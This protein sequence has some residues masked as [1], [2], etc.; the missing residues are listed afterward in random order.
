MTRMTTDRAVADAVSAMT[1]RYDTGDVLDALVTSCRELYPAAAVAV[2]TKAE[3]GALQLMSATSHRSA[4]LELLQQQQQ[5]AGPCVEAMTTGR[6]VTAEG[7]DLQHRWG[8]IGE[9]VLGAGFTGVRAYPMLWRGEALGGL[10]VFLQ[11]HQDTTEGV[12][13]TGQLFADLATLAVVHASDL[14]GD[15]VAS[16]IHEA[17]G[18]RSLVEQAKG[19]IAYRYDVSPAE[20]YELLRQQART[21]GLT[22]SVVA[23]HVVE[24]TSRPPAALPGC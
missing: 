7:E 23:R 1:R 14:P 21:T 5:D 8:G 16:R 6:V 9:A 20:A 3:S 19:V 11:D 18:A 22:V 13:Q 2:L 10:N 17:I 4:E 12:H 15:V 24:S